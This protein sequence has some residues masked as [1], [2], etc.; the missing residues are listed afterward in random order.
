MKWVGLDLRQRESYAFTLIQ[1][2]MLFLLMML[3]SMKAVR[4]QV[5]VVSDQIVQIQ[6]IIYSF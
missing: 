3:L 5:V 2:E 4:D 6:T 1:M